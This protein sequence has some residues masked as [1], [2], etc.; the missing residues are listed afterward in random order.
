MS[1]SG[2][3]MNVHTWVQI[4]IKINRERERAESEAQGVIVLY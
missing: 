4:G 1:I 2:F 3:Y